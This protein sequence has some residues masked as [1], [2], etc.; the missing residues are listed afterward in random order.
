LFRMGTILDDAGDQFLG[1]R[2]DL[3]CPADDPRGMLFC[4]LF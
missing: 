3:S 4:T 1:M 2:P